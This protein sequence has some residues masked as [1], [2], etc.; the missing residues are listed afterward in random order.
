MKDSKIF[1]WSIVD[2]VG[3]LLY[4]V[5]V[6]WI[7][8]NAQNLFGKTDTFWTPVAVLL[9]FVLSAIIVGA[10]VLGRPIYLYLNTFK[11]EAVKLLAYTVG[12]FLIITLIVLAANMIIK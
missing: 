10:L 12:W 5:G 6:A 8:F 4:I 1:I 3:V 2:S 11:N 7:M 9:L